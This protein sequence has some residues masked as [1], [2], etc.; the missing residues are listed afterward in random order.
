MMKMN[1]WVNLT[2]D[3]QDTPQKEAALKRERNLHQE[4]LTQERNLDQDAL[5]ERGTWRKMVG[6]FRSSPGSPGSRI[7]L[8]PDEVGLD[9]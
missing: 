9:A 2:Q 1:P 7:N 8:P 3:H 6:E 5:K 4:A